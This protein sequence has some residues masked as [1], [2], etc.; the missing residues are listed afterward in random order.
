MRRVRDMCSLRVTK[1]AEAFEEELTKLGLNRGFGADYFVKKTLVDLED[2]RMKLHRFIDEYVDTLRSSFINRTSTEGGDL[3]DIKKVVDF[4]QTKV[5]YL[6]SL[7]SLLSG[8][9]NFIF[10]LKFLKF[11]FRNFFEKKI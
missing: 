5:R 7:N 9:F 6:K 2:T 11:F 1:I 4:I 8:M 10:F 3:S